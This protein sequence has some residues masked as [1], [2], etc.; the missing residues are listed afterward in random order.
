MDSSR[1]CYHC[2]CWPC[3]CDSDSTD[4]TV[5]GTHIASTVYV[6]GVKA[7]VNSWMQRRREPWRGRKGRR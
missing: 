6:M 1:R 5:T 4:M 3:R 7:P 2:G